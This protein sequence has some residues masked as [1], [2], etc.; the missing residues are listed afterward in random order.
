MKINFSRFFDLSRF[1]LAAPNLFLAFCFAW[2]GSP[3]NKILGLGQRD[4]ELIISVELMVVL[5]V[6]LIAF[7]SGLKPVFLAGRA[8]KYFGLVLGLAFFAWSAYAN[9]GLWGLGLFVTLVITTYIGLLFRL[10]SDVYARQIKVRWL[11]SVTLFFPCL[12]LAVL[13]QPK[14]DPLKDDWTLIAGMFYFLFLGMLEWYNIYDDLAKKYQG[15][16]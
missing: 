9:D 2:P 15:V 5:A 8:L 12:Y 4:L 6:L 3:V 1:A 13:V 16:I 7:F 10:Y 11:V 14:M